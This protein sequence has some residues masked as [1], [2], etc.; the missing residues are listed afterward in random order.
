MSYYSDRDRDTRVEMETLITPDGKI[1][2]YIYS[3]NLLKKKDAFSDRERYRKGETV[4][5]QPTVILDK[6]T[7]FMCWLIE[8]FDEQDSVFVSVLP[9]GFYMVYTDEKYVVFEFVEAKSKKS[10]KINVSVNLESLWKLLDNKENNVYR[11]CVEEIFEGKEEA[12][13]FLN[14][15]FLSGKKNIQYITNNFYSKK[16]E[17]GCVFVV[18]RILSVLTFLAVISLICTGIY[19][20]ISGTPENKINEILNST[21]RILYILLLISSCLY[22]F[23]HTLSISC[24]SGS[25]T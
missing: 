19:K 12:I 20:N 2:N 13:P 5:I 14:D 15:L 16:E 23:I 18:L 3:K 9:S 25:S 22:T 6:L 24:D 8:E 10:Q 11:S 7:E 1:K 17:S 4:N 21:D